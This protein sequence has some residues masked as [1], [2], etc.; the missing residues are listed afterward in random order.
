M[1]KDQE[2]EDRALISAIRH[3]QVCLPRLYYSLAK[4]D[5]WFL[6]ESLVLQDCNNRASNDEPA[7]VPY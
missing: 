6:F 1:H 2:T 5:P 3:I 7:V 4:P